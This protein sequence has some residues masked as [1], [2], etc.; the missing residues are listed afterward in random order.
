MLDACI[1]LWNHAVQCPAPVVAAFPQSKGEGIDGPPHGALAFLRCP[2]PFSTLDTS[3]GPRPGGPARK[4]GL[5]LRLRGPAKARSPR[6]EPRGGKTGDIRMKTRRIAAVAGIA[7]ALGLAFPLQPVHAD[8]GWV[9]EGQK[10]GYNWGKVKD[11][12]ICLQISGSSSGDS[13]FYAYAN[14]VGAEVHYHDADGKWSPW[15]N[16]SSTQKIVVANDSNRESWT[17][18]DKFEAWVREGHE[19]L[20][21]YARI[22]PQGNSDP[23]KINLVDLVKKHTDTICLTADWTGGTSGAFNV[24][25]KWRLRVTSSG[26][27]A[28]TTCGQ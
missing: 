5:R 24:V 20:H 4:S 16:D 1:T 9:V 22:H 23:L 6:I 2:F 3:G 17:C 25:A 14:T 12:R 26:P 11:F 7:M 28:L 19:S 13:D 8:H 10:G 18:F 15:T 21:I 27:W